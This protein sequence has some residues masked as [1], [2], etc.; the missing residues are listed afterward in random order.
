MKKFEDWNWRI[1]I[2][3][4]ICY[5]LIISS[6]FMYDF[7]T[8]LNKLGKITGIS[9]IIIGYAI[10]LVARFQ[11]KDRFSILPSAEKGF[12]TNGIYAYLRHPIYSGSFISAL[13]IFIYLSVFAN[14]L[15]SVFLF[16]LLVLYAWMQISRA[17]KEEQ[18]FMK[19]YKEEYAKYKRR[20]LF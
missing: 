9:Y 20:T 17:K 11:L 2:I 19:R 8:G 12:I 4:P 16:L 1:K 7:L 10:M 15:L 14:V 3:G 13:G 6:L 5:S 18:E